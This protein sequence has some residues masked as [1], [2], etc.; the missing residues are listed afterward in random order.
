MI[1]AHLFPGPL[2]VVGDV[3]G[4]IDAL[5][6]KV[7]GKLFRI[8]HLG[9]LNSAMLLGCLAFVWAALLGAGDGWQYASVCLLS[10]LALG[11]DLAL[12]PALLA[13]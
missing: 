3:H 5:D 12:P 9:D 10:G 6:N 1:L 13:K 7:A 2:D 11:A 4:E 8:G